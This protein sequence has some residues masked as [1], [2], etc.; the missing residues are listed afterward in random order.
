MLFVLLNVAPGLNL[1]ILFYGL[2]VKS[3]S[4]RSI[5]NASKYIYD[6]DF[7]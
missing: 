1:R 5:K 3:A 6:F 2:G 4:A 7:D